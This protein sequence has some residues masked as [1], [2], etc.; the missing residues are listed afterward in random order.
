MTT[1]ARSMERAFFMG[2]RRADARSLAAV[3]TP[4]KRAA[5]DEEH[6][7]PVDHAWVLADLESMRR[8]M[9]RTS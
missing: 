9:R 7:A 8:V 3:A 1:K 6:R 5:L 4:P 2:D